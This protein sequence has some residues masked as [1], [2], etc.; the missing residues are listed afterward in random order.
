MHEFGS[1]ESAR[2]QN[3]CADLP[4]DHFPFSMTL[5]TSSSFFERP[6]LTLKKFPKQSFPIFENRGDL[7]HPESRI[8]EDCANQG[9]PS[10]SISDS[11]DA[12]TRPR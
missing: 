4:H 2:S 6:P 9:K 5:S 12:T 1:S 7:L 8:F 11:A 3:P 10:F